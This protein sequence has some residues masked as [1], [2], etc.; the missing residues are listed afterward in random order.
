MFLW[1]MR[2]YTEDHKF[3]LTTIGKIINIRFFDD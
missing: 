2:E 3:S 1:V